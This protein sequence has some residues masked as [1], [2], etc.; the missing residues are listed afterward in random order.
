L[1]DELF[2]ATREFDGFRFSK[3][4]EAGV[5]RDEFS[6]DGTDPVFSAFGDG[7]INNA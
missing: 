4:R 2:P 6:F 5:N 3:L 7:S 1:D